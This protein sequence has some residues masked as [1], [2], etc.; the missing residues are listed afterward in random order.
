MTIKR[1][2]PPHNDIL[3]PAEWRIVD[4][5]RHGLTNKQIAARRGISE[6]AVKYHVANAIAKLGIKNKKALRFW[7]GAPMD[8]QLARGESEMSTDF[9]IQGV[10]QIART[11]SDVERSKSWY[12]EV[13]GLELLYAFDKL[14]FF[15]CGGVRLML[16]ETE[17]AA[18]K[19]SIVY[20]WVP[21]VNVAYES[22]SDR[23]VEFVSAPHRV[24][25]HD[26]GV[27]EWMA[28][29]NDPEGRPLAI[30]SNVGND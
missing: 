5:V 16:S 20:L 9:Q 24:H 14:A 2:R 7:E 29:F 8:S 17:V 19:E 30:M 26:N 4:A 12:S 23:G 3:T 11:V 6:D 22:L 25:K 15:N 1:G 21:N 28:F 10:G 27:E 13:L 18:E